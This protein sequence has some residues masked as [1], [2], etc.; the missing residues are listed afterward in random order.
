MLGRALDEAVCRYLDVPYAK[1]KALARR[2][3]H[4]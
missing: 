3:T 4:E 2:A 1:L